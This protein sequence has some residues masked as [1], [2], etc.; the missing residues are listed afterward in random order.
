MIKISVSPSSFKELEKEILQAMEDE[1]LKAIIKVCDKAIKFQWAKFRSDGGY[2]DQTGQLRSSTG[3]I[4]YKD[5]KVMKE[6][7]ELSPYGT[8]KAPGLKEGRD[9]A[10]SKLRESEGWGILFVG[11]KDYASYLEAKNLS[12]LSDAELI[13]SDELLEELNSIFVS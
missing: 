7:F 10:F 2:D 9:Y 1:V 3:Y 5:G 8:D 4:I 6:R 11:G 13:V 12:V